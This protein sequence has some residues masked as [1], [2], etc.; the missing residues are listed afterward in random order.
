M[1]RAK[2]LNPP[3]DMDLTKSWLENLVK[4]IDMKILQGPYVSYVDAPG[5]RGITAVVMIETSH[6]A[7]H[8]WDEQEPALLQFDLYTCGCLD[9][10]QVLDKMNEFFQ[11]T[12]LEY[13]VYDRED[14]FKLI[15][16]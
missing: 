3:R 9:T 8:V 13:L 4:D 16:E 12:H 11:F 7:F 14:T 1:V 2:V 5:N 6:I 10:Q 15:K